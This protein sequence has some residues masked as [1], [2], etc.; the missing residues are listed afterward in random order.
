MHW[1]DYMGIARICQPRGAAT[2]PTATSGAWKLP[3]A[4]SPSP[5]VLMLDEPAAGLNPQEKKDLQAPDWPACATSTG[6]AVLAR[7]NTTWAW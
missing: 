5:S 3:A 7:S 2:W 1:L 6:V 4:W